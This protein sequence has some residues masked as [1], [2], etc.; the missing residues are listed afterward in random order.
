MATTPLYGADPLSAIDAEIARLNAEYEAK[1]SRTGGEA[2]ADTGLALLQGAVGLGQAAYGV[3]NVATAGL[4]DR[5]VGLSGNFAETQAILNRAKSAPMQRDQAAASAAFDKGIGSG[6]AAYITN[7]ALLADVA[8]QSAPSLIPTAAVASR[9]ARGVGALGASAEEVARRAT[10]AGIRAGGLQTAGATNVDA[11]NAIEAAGG[12]EN[13]QQLGG[14]GA[15]GIAG[16][17]TAALSRLTG[18]GALEAAVAARLSGVATPAVTSL[19]RAIAGGAA[20]EGV[21]ETLQSGLEQASTNLFAPGVDVGEGV[22][23]AMAVGGLLGTALGGGLGA[24]HGFRRPSQH[25]ADLNAANEDAAAAL[26]LPPGGAITDLGEISTLPAPAEDADITI[27]QLPAAPGMS[28]EEELYARLQQVADAP[29]QPP[30]AQVEELP[31]VEPVGDLPLMQVDDIGGPGVQEFTSAAR[32]PQWFNTREGLDLLGDPVELAALGRQTTTETAGPAATAPGQMDFGFD[33]SPLQRA[34]NAQLGVD[35]RSGYQPIDWVEGE[36]LGPDLAA[37]PNPMNRG[38]GAQ[39]LPLPSGVPPIELADFYATPQGEV[40]PLQ[41]YVDAGGADLFGAPLQPRPV[42]TTAEPAPVAT[43]PAQ[44]SLVLEPEPAGWKQFLAKTAGIKPTAMRGKVWDQFVSAAQTA[45]VR[46]G[47]DATAFM[48]Q[49]AAAADP[50]TAPTFVAQMSEKYGVV[51]SV[52]AAAAPTPVAPA[53]AV[54]TTAPSEDIDAPDGPFDTILTGLRN[55][56]NTDELDASWAATL[57]G[58]AFKALPRDYQDDLAQEYSDLYDGLEKN[59]FFRVGEPIADGKAMSAA[60]FEPQVAKFNA[61]RVARGMAPVVTHDTVQQFRLRTNAAAPNDAAGVYMPDG[62]LHVIR[63]NTAGKTQLAFTLLHEQGHEGMRG[64]LGDRIGAVTNRMWA[65]PALRDR[66]RARARTDSLSRS[67]AAE[68]VL[69]DMLADEERLAPSIWAK[70][71]SAVKQTAAKLFGV[72]DLYVSDTQVDAL[73]NDTARYLHAPGNYTGGELGDDALWKNLDAVIG[74]PETAMNDPAFS[75][76]EQALSS[77][78][79]A[80]T[81]AADKPQPLDA[82]FNGVMNAARKAVGKVVGQGKD[83]RGALLD[84]MPL[85]QIVERYDDQ[86][87]VDVDGK[88]YRP[89]RELYK[90]KDLKHAEFSRTIQDDRALKYGSESV[91]TSP[92]SLSAEW[93]K[94]GHKDQRKFTALNQMQQ[95]ATHYRV[96]PDR[97]WEDQS[98]LNYQQHGFDEVERKRAWQDLRKLWSTVGADGQAIYKKSQALYDDMWHQRLKAVQTSYEKLGGVDSTKK[99]QVKQAVDL[100]LQQIRQGPYSPLSRMGDHFVTVRDNTG[101]TVSFSAYDTDAE[102]NEAYTTMWNSLTPEQRLAKAEGG[103]S[104]VKSQRG[105]QQAADDGINYGEIAR[106]GEVA[107]T[108]VPPGDNQDADAFRKSLRDALVEVYLQSLPTHSLMNHANARKGVDGFTLDAFRAFNAYSMKAARNIAAIKHDGDITE[109]LNNLAMPARA[110][111]EAGGLADTSGLDRVQ[112]AVREQHAA[113]QSPEHS[114]AADN[115]GQAGF[116]M[117]LTSPSQMFIN[118]LQTPMVAFPRLAGQF[119]TGGAVKSI[120]TAF[121]QFFASG[122]DMLGAN[123]KLDP[124]IR[125]VMDQIRIRGKLDITLGHDLAGLAEGDYSQMSARRRAAMRI[126]STFMHRSEVFNRQVT[127]HAAIELAMKKMNA[128]GRLSQAQLDDLIDVGE[129]AI[130]DTQFNYSQFNRPTVM[131]GPWRKLLFQFQTYRLNMLAM[132]ARDI[133]NALKGKDAETR[134]QARTTLGWLLGAQLTFAGA[135]GTTLSPFVFGLADLFRDDDELLDSRTAFSLA[136]PQWLAHGLLSGVLDMSRVGGDTLVP[137]LGDSKYAPRDSKADDTVAYHILQNIGPWAGVAADTYS[138]ALAML[139]GDFKEA[140]KNL[141]P[142]PFRDVADAVYSLN[143]IEDSR[144]IV[145]RDPNGWDVLAQVA[146]LR[147]GGRREAEQVRGA[148]YQAS[149]HASTLRKAAIDQLAL[150]TSIGDDSL[151]AEAQG[152]IAEWNEKYPDMAIKGGDVSRA[153]RSRLRAQQTA[154]EYGVPSGRTPPPSI[155]QALNLGE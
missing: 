3:G 89:L 35:Q 78:V 57:Q 122:G 8:V 68:E 145:Y 1:R 36:L 140:W 104:V 52:P 16:L 11:I 109:H 152:R 121:K 63:E 77:A 24:V 72:G 144:G 105:S 136:A 83:V 10:T 148:S 97:A 71:R 85:N 75:R 147:S 32:T 27:D 84:F 38:A 88:E 155:L 81:L 37:L 142:K 117:Y 56:A 132:M 128:K 101:A 151:V 17:G 15:A 82:D 130:D 76:A 127:A 141:P 7:P 90:Q 31:F 106:L 116:I 13:L 66:I 49:F 94:F 51:P 129:R 54:A 61:Q 154:T 87:V 125:E 123:S 59:R 33:Q 2:A 26:G 34:I 134:A 91:T 86:F 95:F 45:G 119:G 137:F 20:K 139:N 143:G 39:P 41:S 23:E 18:A 9:V 60:D 19:P 107:D 46:P 22:G 114:R 48:A 12:D 126:A 40:S 58:D 113:A 73:L 124:Q 110:I 115:I 14:L 92:M 102:A 53:A 135:L 43:D 70:M 96:W 47:P 100:A 69:V 149:K 21:E 120:N 30:L 50:A 64:L 153:T 133:R 138:G 108:L 62:T 79:E 6:L 67:R 25:R 29:A 93:E 4:L 44:P 112:R 118:A 5:G 131:Q 111:R 55:A 150:G 28:P 146:G 74:S 80:A 98:P 65:S 42:A 99:L 103:W